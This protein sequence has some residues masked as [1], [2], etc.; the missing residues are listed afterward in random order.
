MSRFKSDFLRTLDERGF[1]HQIS[2][3]AGLDELFAKETVTAYIG[4]DPTASSLHV[5]HLTQIMMLHW[6]QKTG[7]QPISLM[8]GGTG[9]V[10][11]PSFKEEA[12]KLMTIDMIEDNI[13]SLKHVFANYLDYDRAENPALMINNADWLRGLNY[14]EFLRDVGRHFSVNRMLSFDSVKT[15]LDREQSLSFLEFNYMILQAYDFVELNQRTGCRLQMGGSDQWGNIINGIDLGHRMGTPQLYALTSPL[16]TTSSGAKMG[17]SASGAVWLNKDLLPVY[18]FWQYWRNTEDADVVRFAKLFTTLPMDEIARIAT[19]GGSE[20]NEAKKILA[21]EVTA[22]LHGRAAAEEAAET[23]RKTFEEGALAENL[24]SIEVP[25][26]ELDAG[27][28]VLSLIVRAGLASS[29][30]EARRHVQGGAVKINEQGVSDER[31][32]IGTGEVTGD[33]VIKLSVGK[34]KH[35]LVR[36]A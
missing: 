28:G 12:R 20:I 36:P 27:V 10:G 24:P 19:L 22:I 25:T 13:T 8:G 6:M 5:G 9:M 15:R 31:Q 21:T 18:D 16:L 2:D 29:N 3:E 26:S 33:G 4:Y 23:A 35:V 32:I 30:G 17:K 11:D 14:L 1:I 7:H 34:K